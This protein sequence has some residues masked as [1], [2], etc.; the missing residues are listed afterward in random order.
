MG[1]AITQCGSQFS[2]SKHSIKK[3]QSV[4]SQLNQLNRYGIDSGRDDQRLSMYP[5]LT[6]F[7]VYSGSASGGSFSIDGKAKCF[8]SVSHFGVLSADVQRSNSIPESGDTPI[9]L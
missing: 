6:K 4:C 9:W 2:H 5:N 1:Y 3:L 8:V 7:S